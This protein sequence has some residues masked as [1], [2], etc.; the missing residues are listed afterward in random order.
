[1]ALPEDSNL[2]LTVHDYDPMTFAYQGASWTD[3]AYPVGV[4]W[5]GYW[6]RRA[7]REGADA[8][9]AYAMEMDIPVFMGEFGTTVD[10]DTASRSLWAAS[11]CRLYEQRGFSWSWWDYKEPVMG[12]Y[13]PSEDAWD[14]PILRS[15]LSSDTSVLELGNAPSSGSDLIVNG[16]FDGPMGWFLVQLD[17]GKGT[18]ATDSGYAMASVRENPLRESWAV[19]ICQ[20]N[21][22]LLAGQDYALSFTAWADTATTINAWVGHGADPWATYG[23]S[24]AL[25]LGRVPTSFA[26]GFQ[27]TSAGGGDSLGEVCI[28]LGVTRAQ[29]RIDS[30][31]LLRSSNDAVRKGPAR[32][33]TRI[34]F[35]GN[36]LVGSGAIPSSRWLVDAK[37]AKVFPLSWKSSARGWTADLRLAP[38]G[39]ILFLEDSGLRILLDR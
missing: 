30:V 2:I 17:S 10:G 11:K 28:N 37:G 34:R 32:S 27:M 16:Q 18:F 29:V 19:E 13:R 39:K 14:E 15:L 22:V 7:A 8:I 1:L 3:P 21:L 36:E 38:D 31:K 24:K 25:R 20:K 5:G 4:V 12:V 9:A 26:T 35:V 6:D 23:T 33:N